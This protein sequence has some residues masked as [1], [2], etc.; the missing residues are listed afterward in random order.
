MTRGELV[1]Q[2]GRL[3]GRT[4]TN[5]Q[6]SIQDFLNQSIR[7]FALLRPWAGLKQNMNAFADGT[8]FITL[9]GWVERPM[10]VFDVSNI[11]PVEPGAIWDY[12]FETALADKTTGLAI[13]WRDAGTLPTTKVPTGVLTIESTDAGDTEDIRIAGFS[14]VSEASGTPLENQIVHETMTLTGTSPVSSSNSYT[15][16]MSISKNADTTGNIYVR[17]AAASAVL[18]ASLGAFED[19]TRYKRLEFLRIPS[20]GTKFEI[21]VL[22]K[23]IELENDAQSAEPAIPEDYLLWNT[24]GLELVALGE[25]QAGLTFLQKARAL[26]DQE[27]FKDKNFGDQA[28]QMIPITDYRNSERRMVD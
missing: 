23:P 20:A 9:P 17:D 15:R 14:H 3:T 7:E 18:I 12:Q 2:I 10:Y 6:T 13:E 25:R 28:L 8:A 21:R 27:D 4:D 24:A 16:V 5:R 11:N 22:R 19:Q 1:T 26:A